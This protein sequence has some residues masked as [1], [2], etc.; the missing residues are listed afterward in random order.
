[1][2]KQLDQDD[3]TILGDE[4]EG[5][6]DE[7]D[8]SDDEDA[9]PKKRQKKKAREDTPNIKATAYIFIVIAPPRTAHM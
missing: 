9:L 8:A 5:E 1:L 7:L 2:E 4:I 6:V 3:N